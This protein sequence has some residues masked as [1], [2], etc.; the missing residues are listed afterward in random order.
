M[1]CMQGMSRKQKKDIHKVAPT[2]EPMQSRNFHNREL[3]SDE[4]SA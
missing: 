4:V 1:G 3:S 2:L